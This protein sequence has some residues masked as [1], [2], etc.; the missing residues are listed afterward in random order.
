ME[1]PVY[2]SD[3]RLVKAMSLLRVAAYTNGRKAVSEQDLFLLQHLL[4]AAPDQSSA[5]FDWLLTHVA[6][7]TQAAALDLNV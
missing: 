3:R 4:W 5:I 6:T 7:D 1:P 2:V